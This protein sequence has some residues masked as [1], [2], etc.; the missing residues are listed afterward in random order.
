MNS[1]KQIREL[2]I[3]TLPGD[4]LSFKNQISIL[5]SKV[6]TISDAIDPFVYEQFTTIQSSNVPKDVHDATTQLY[7]IHSKVYHTLTPTQELV[8]T[9]YHRLLTAI[10]RYLLT[11]TT[12]ELLI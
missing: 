10:A 12:D 9:T 2:H 5:T 4:S 7:E 3:S 1:E 11:T 8:I 6:K